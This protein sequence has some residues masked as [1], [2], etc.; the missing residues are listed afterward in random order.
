MCCKSAVW[1]RRF[2][3]CIL[4]LAVIG[5][6]AESVLGS[7]VLSAEGLLVGE[8]VGLSGATA[9]LGAP[10]SE[11]ALFFEATP[12]GWSGPIRR[13][14]TD[15]GATSFGQY[16]AIEGDLAV[17]GAP[18]AGV[19]QAPG[20]AF[21]YARGDGAWEQVA[22]L[23]PDGLSPGA[24]FGLGVAA[25]RGR[26]A[27]GAPNQACEVPDP[28][29]SRGCG[30]VRI[31]DVDG[32]G[33]REAAVLTV[34]EG[35]R[36]FRFGNSVALDG[37]RL[38]VSAL[39]GEFGTE[40]RLYVYE[41]SG[42]AWGVTAAIDAPPGGSPSVPRSDT[43]GFDLALDGDVL[44]VSEPGRVGGTVFVYRRSA[45][46]WSLEETLSRARGELGPVSL[47]GVQIDLEGNR[48][49]ASAAGRVYD[50]RSLGAAFV[51]V[52]DAAG[53]WI[54]EAELRSAEPVI[55]F[56]RDVALDGD[57]I[58]VGVNDAEGTGAAFL[59]RRGAEGWAQVP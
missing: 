5:C 30:Q 41:W 56:G 10:G 54:Q 24:L 9:L 57:R 44:A 49:V 55:G 6:D 43:Y 51:Y 38:V 59:F 19:S 29:T 12:S 26:V 45:S 39:T 52:R 47:F 50:G 11:E 25:A 13:A 40:G 14:A 1:L 36:A 48:L 53:A 28:A 31:Y 33:A 16:L 21:V 17:V 34:P 3:P 35:D 2:L 20:W 37:D 18:P 23:R 4:A 8:R 15:A 32:A 22:A 58:L 46:G 42:G 27:V 7:G